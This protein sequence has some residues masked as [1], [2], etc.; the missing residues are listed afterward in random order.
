M[1]TMNSEKRIGMG[2]S[3]VPR[4]VMLLFSLV[5]LSLAYCATYGAAT[6][7]ALAS[8]ET[9][10]PQASLIGKS[11]MVLCQIVSCVAPPKPEIT[12]VRAETYITPGGKVDVR[13]HNFFSSDMKGGSVMLTL[14]HNYPTPQTIK[15]EL[16]I[17]GW[18]DQA[19][20]GQIEPDIQGVLDQWA[21]IQVGRSDGVSSDPFKVLFRPTRTT[22][23]LPA[24]DVAVT[25]CSQNADDNKC[26][27]HVA[28]PW[29]FSDAGDTVYAW[30]STYVGDDS[31]TD[32]YSL[33]PKNGWRVTQIPF[34]QSGRCANDTASMT[35][36]S[37]LNVQGP[38]TTIINVSWNSAC[39]SAYQFGVVLNGPVGVPWK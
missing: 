28:F 26:N 25:A 31:G 34:L 35:A 14:V 36:T 8:G 2:A 22:A 37:P 24:R 18:T 19:A 17:L 10:L 29:G 21:W 11:S 38:P 6:H 13:G 3:F 27:A 39:L 16:K 33:T 4:R 7:A 23:V 30:H 20:F 9:G 15:Y 32:Q 5:M 1:D 12:D